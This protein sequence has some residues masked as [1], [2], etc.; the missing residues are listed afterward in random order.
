MMDA[1]RSPYPFVTRTS[2]FFIDTLFS[3]SRPSVFD[4]AL[5]GVSYSQEVT[6]VVVFLIIFLRHF[7]VYSIEKFIGRDGTFP[8]KQVKITKKII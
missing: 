6:T 1:E 7:L 2:S 8:R 5:I 4:V 3:P